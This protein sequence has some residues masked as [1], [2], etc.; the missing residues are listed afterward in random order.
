MV[1]A[2]GYGQLARGIELRPFM[3]MYVPVVTSVSDISKIW[4]MGIYRVLARDGDLEG[5][6][7][8]I[9]F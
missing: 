7:D 2:D 8:I 4:C 1:F 6:G 9:H 5:G 3:Y